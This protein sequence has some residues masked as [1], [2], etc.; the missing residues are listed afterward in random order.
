MKNLRKKQVSYDEVITYEN[1]YKMWQI[2]RKTCKNKKAVFYFSLNLN[3]NINYIYYVLKNKIYNPS[4]YRL[5]MIFEPKP[6]L[7]MSQ[8]IV[9][10]IVNHFIA[11][12]YLIPILENTL[13]DTNVATRVGKGSSYAMKKLKSYFNK[14]LINNKNKEIYCLKIDVSKYFYT[15]DHEILR[16]KLEK[17]ILDK[18]IINLINKV[19]NETNKPYINLKVKEYQEKYKIE[20]PFYYQGKGLSIGAMSSQFLAIYYLNDLDH[21]IKEK[22]GCKYYIRYMDDFLILDCDKD[23]LLEVYRVIESELKK[24]KLTPNSKSNLYRSTKGFSFLGYTYK[25]CNNKLQISCCKKT[26][27]RIVKK[28]NYL[29]NNEPIKYGK[30]LSSYY[31][32]FINKNEDERKYFKMKLIDKYKMYKKQYPYYILIMKEGIFFKTFY[33]DALIIW[34]LF[35]YKYV[36]D[37]T[38][39][40]TTPYDRVLRVLNKKDISYI[41][42]SQDKEIIKVTKDDENYISYC[43]LSKKSYDKTKRR[44]S[45]LNKLDQI[46]EIYP[47]NY[48]VIDELL[49]SMLINNN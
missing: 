27:K 46:L 15:I 44:E 29:K 1:I 12:Y 3:T 10:K 7:V 28:L 2:I 36:N 14:L 20:V 43:N 47:N 6:R 22:L 37:T 41:V 19:I 31:G 26:S 21:L 45:L 39:F 40:G 33:N 17:N 9:D 49:D 23:R 24:L 32:Y 30:T 16:R 35:E 4:E 5:F 13:I 8:T 38:S 11:N 25:V 48:Q 42:I 18:D 34:Y